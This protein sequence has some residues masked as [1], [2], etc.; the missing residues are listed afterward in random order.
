MSLAFGAF[1]GIDGIDIVAHADRLVW[2]FKFASTA[3]CA[4]LGDNFVGH[5]LVFLKIR[6]DYIAYLLFEAAGGHLF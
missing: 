1:V 6:E 2:A 5:A 4:L 3:S